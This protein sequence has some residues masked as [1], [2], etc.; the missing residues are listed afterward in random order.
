M[1]TETVAVLGLGYVGLP[2]AGACVQAGLK[3][4]GY[5][6][7]E[8]VVGALT[9]G[10][11]HIDDVS[12]VDLAKWI[13]RGL[14]FTSDSEAL[15]SV[16]VF[17]ICVPTPL[18]ALGDPDLDAIIHAGQTV[19]GAIQRSTRH[20]LVVLESTTYPGTTDEVL[21]PLLEGNG[22]KAG[23]DFS[24]AF[25]P[26]RVD[27]GNDN[28]SVSNTTKLVGGYTADCAAKASAFYNMFI[29]SVVTVNGL[30]ETE[31]AKLLENTYRHVNIALVNEF[32]KVCHPLG[33]D[34]WEVIRAAATKPYGFQA[35]YPG[36]GVGGHC[37]PIDPKYLAHKI[38]A[39]LGETFR[40]VELASDINAGMPHY[41]VTR[42][43]DLLNKQ[44]KPVH[45]ARVLLLGVTYKAD[46]ADLRES[47]AFMV[48]RLLRASGALVSYNDPFID[49]WVVDGIR[50]PRI[51]DLPEANHEWDCVV[52]LQSHSAYLGEL[53]KLSGEVL[54]DTRGVTQAGSRWIRL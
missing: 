13:D 12:D 27:P 23:R 43:Q 9:S 50:V 51:M 1:K 26:E 34:F 54:F 21:R 48:A 40:F 4:L 20:P 30:R 41:V 38:K 6:I 29:D 44:S 42:L 37:I 39:E 8:E 53:N 15:G 7:S 45:G 46:L 22:L 28:Y 32:A 16:D 2:L 33:I 31:M 49:E 10:A 19:A 17:V 25:S 24:L 35:F 5:D 18:T 47:P 11:S 14:S 36:P 3:V 52:L